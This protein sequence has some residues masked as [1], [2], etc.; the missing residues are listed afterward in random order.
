[1]SQSKFALLGP[2]DELLVNIV[3]GISL[4]N[5][6]NLSLTCHH[7]RPIAQEALVQKSTVRLSHIWNLVNTLQRR[8]GLTSALTR[9]S[10][11]PWIPEKHGFSEFDQHE[12]TEDHSLCYA[13]GLT[14][15]LSA[16]IAVLF[17]MAKS[18]RAISLDA[19][20]IPRVF[21]LRNCFSANSNGLTAV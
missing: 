12:Q 17:T 3:N 20:S 19:G 1:M 11:G 6:K 18:L 5:L 21:I 2:P 4:V 16:G 14:G 15:C 7:L 13:Q 10:L 8:P 9:L